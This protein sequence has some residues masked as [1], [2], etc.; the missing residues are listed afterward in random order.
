MD[1][2]KKIQL[3]LQSNLNLADYPQIRSLKFVKEKVACAIWII[4]DQLNITYLSANDLEIVLRKKFHLR[5]IS[6]QSIRSSLNSDIENIQRM[7]EGGVTLYDISYKGI[8]KILGVE[9]KQ[10]HNVKSLHKN[11]QHELSKFS[12]PYLGKTDIKTACRMAE[13]YSILFCFENSVRR[14]IENKLS[15]KYG[16]DW[17]EKVANSKLKRKIEDRKKKE[18]KNRWHSERGA[19]P[20]FY[21]DIDDLLYL[22]RKERKAFGDFFPNVNW[23]ESRLEDITLSRNI[24]AHNNPLPS[25]EIQRLILHFNDWNIQLS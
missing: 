8:S 1:R 15:N 16:P 9:I 6:P 7:M 3:I 17:F 18:K 22:I 14:F 13:V 20:I 11:I 19:N 12:I 24:V 5:K 21:T 2:K 10:K 25:R 23:I 4:K